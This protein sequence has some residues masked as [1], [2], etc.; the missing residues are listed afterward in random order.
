PAETD[1]AHRPT[2]GTAVVSSAPVACAHG[3]ANEAPPW[4]VGLNDRQREAVHH[5]AGPLLVVAG[6]GTG[7]TRTLAA[8]VARLVDEGA[9]AE[10]IL[11]LT[12]SRRAAEEMIDRVA[13]LTDRHAAAQLWG[14]TFHAVANRLLRHYGDA[15]GLSPG[16]TVLDQGDASDLFGLLRSEHLEAS[17]GGR[18]FP[19]AETIASVYSRVVNSSVPLVDV[20]RDHYPWCIDHTEA[21]SAIFRS[22]SRRKRTG[23]VLDYDDLLLFWRALLTDARSGPAVRD[24]FDHVFV[25]EYQDTNGIQADITALLAGPAASV[26]VVGDDAQ[27]IY[28]FRAATAANLAGFCE[29]FPD[30][31]VVTLEQNYRSTSPI[32]TAANAVLATSP[33]HL[34]KTLWT[35]RSGRER[36]V[37]ARC[38]DEAAQSRWVADQVLERREQGIALRDQCVLFR[39]SHHSD[40]LELELARRD[41]PYVKYGGL[42]FLEAAHVKDLLSLLRVLEN[43][44]DELAWS[45]VLR[46]IEGVGTAT[47]RRLLDELGVAAGP[48]TTSSPAAPVASSPLAR[49]LGGEGRIPV[50]AADSAAELR[51]AW[52]DCVRT[53]LDIA[54]Q[55][56]RLQPFCASHFQRRYRDHAA[57]LGDLES[58]AVLGSGYASRERFLTDLVLE[59]PNSTG[60]LA[61]P[62]HLDD[63][64]L[65]LST[66]HS[67]KGG[68]WRAVTLLHASDGNLPS[69]L[70]A[71][72]QAQLDEELRLLYVALTRAQDHLSVTFPLRYHPRRFGRDARHHY[73]QLSR[74]L[75]PVREHF[76]EVAAGI[77]PGCDASVAA[78]PGDR[79]SIGDEVDAALESLW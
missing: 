60:D 7:K 66:I 21:F 29:R 23:G 15:V 19:R 49:F 35:E 34:P 64:Y 73:A 39:A 44:A 37:L 79:I 41:I 28:G 3:L 48:A 2:V 43:P 33:R 46:M 8:R 20:V 25:D 45:R 59:P 71:G 42:K 63:D 12:F 36:P 11:L 6:A 14:G 17:D 22:Y 50:A 78:A 47:L 67:A 52:A 75:E 57:R 31:T 27:A 65:I 68:E 32:L 5:P 16:F 30:A 74:F 38:A 9:A 53:P 40:H 77:M 18:R 69:D 58:L 1:E 4:A 72:D 13:A 56:D 61:G 62:P 10:R 26:T 76:D 55:I 70:A 24:R 51:A 54:A